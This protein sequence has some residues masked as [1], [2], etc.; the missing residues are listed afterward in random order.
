MGS[1]SEDLA[2]NDELDWEAGRRKGEIMKRDCLQEKE[3]RFQQSQKGDEV[4][5]KFVSKN[6]LG[7]PGFHR[8]DDVNIKI[9]LV[10]W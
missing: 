9:L 4:P 5:T 1:R 10:A 6:L 7:L 8:D 2:R 3:M